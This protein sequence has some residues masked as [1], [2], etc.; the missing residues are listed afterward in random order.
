MQVSR[1]GRT[2]TMIDGI[3]VM[4]VFGS[5]KCH[6]AS[7]VEEMIDDDEK[8]GFLSRHLVT[9]TTSRAVRGLD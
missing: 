6:G 2:S 3:G 5:G 7:A 8:G 4:S 1:L 9:V